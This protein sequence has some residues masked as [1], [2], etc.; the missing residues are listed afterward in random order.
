MVTVTF[1]PPDV[2]VDPSCILPGEESQTE[3]K[4]PRGRRMELNCM[5]D[6]PFNCG[7]AVRE[8]NNIS[9][10]MPIPTG[11][12]KGIGPRAGRVG[13]F[14]MRAKFCTVHLTAVACAPMVEDALPPMASR[15][16]QRMHMTYASSNPGVGR[17]L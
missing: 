9:T 1:M 13:V 10:A 15:F 6:L 11:L 17:C 7:Q 16:A 3:V 4:V 12:D 8:L 2:K 5:W 14:R